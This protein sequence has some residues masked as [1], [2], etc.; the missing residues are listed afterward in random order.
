MSV[1][2]WT[3]LPALKWSVRTKR[4]VWRFSSCSSERDDHSPESI[5]V[6][7]KHS[8]HTLQLKNQFYM[9]TETSIQYVSQRE[10]IQP[11]TAAPHPYYS[12]LKS[13]KNK[14]DITERYISKYRGKLRSVASEA[15]RIQT[16]MKRNPVET[17]NDSGPM[18]F[19]EL[20][21]TKQC[22][23]RM[24]PVTTDLLS[25]MATLVF[26]VFFLNMMTAAEFL[27]RWHS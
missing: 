20:S 24:Y 15:T 27:L 16:T 17:R 18:Q 21:A 2:P 10:V 26:P 13:S 8:T 9:W 12:N 5:D 1:S 23:A 4:S 6:Q 22:R 14:T 3:V 7:C 19:K 25:L 11:V